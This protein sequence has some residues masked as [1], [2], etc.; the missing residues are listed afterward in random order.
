MPKE[1]TTPLAIQ[2]SKNNILNQTS[3]LYPRE[4]S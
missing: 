4:L 2:Y 1:R 3:K